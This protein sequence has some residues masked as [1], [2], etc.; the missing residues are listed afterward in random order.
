MNNA[1]LLFREKEIG[2]LEPG[3][4]AD[5]A[6]IDRDILMCPEDDLRETQVLRTYLAGKVNFDSSVAPSPHP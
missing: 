2:S 4:F 3:K 5:L 6:I 1:W